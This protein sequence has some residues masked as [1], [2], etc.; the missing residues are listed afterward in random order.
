VGYSQGLLN[1]Q[2]D[3]FLCHQCT[4]PQALLKLSKQVGFGVSF[5]DHFFTDCRP[6]RFQFFNQKISVILTALTKCAEV[7]YQ[8]K[9][10]QVVLVAAPVKHKIWG[11]VI[12]SSGERLSGVF[13]KIGDA[14]ACTN[15]FGYYNLEASKGKYVIYTRYFGYE[16][17][18]AKPLQ[19]FGDQE[20]EIVL[21]QQKSLPA[22]TISDTLGS[23]M[24]RNARQS[25]GHYLLFKSRFETM[26]SP[27]G[28][29]D[30]MRLVAEQPGI[31]TGVDGLGGIHVRGGN[32]DQNLILLDDVPVYNPGHMLGI[33]S[34]FNPATLSNTK[35]WK[36][37]FP[38]RYG[39]RVS[40]VLDVR[41]RD[42]NDQEFH[43]QVGAGLFAANALVEGPIVRGR[44][45]FLLAGRITYFDPIISLLHQRP[46]V[47]SGDSSD[48]RPEYQ[49][50]DLNLKANYQLN[51]ANRVY[52][53]VYL[54]GDQFYNPYEITNEV[55]TGGRY[56]DRYDLGSDWGN[57][58]VAARWNYIF[59]QKNMFVNTTL[60]YSEFEYNSDL[61]FKSVFETPD[62]VARDV[63]NYAQAYRTLIS[64]V[65]VKSDFT[66]NT[67][68]KWQ[69]RWGGAVTR[70]VLR[71]GALSVNFKLPKQGQVSIDSLE[72]LLANRE[73]RVN[74]EIEAYLETTY[75]PTPHWQVLAGINTSLFSTDNVVY[76]L[77]L[78]RVQVVHTHGRGWSQW[79]ALTKNGQ[80]LHQIGSFNLSLP[81]ELWVPTTS[82]IKPETARQ[83][84]VGFGKADDT[85]SFQTELYYKKQLNT[86]LLR[87]AN[88]ALLAGGAEDGSGWEDRVSTGQ[89]ASRGLEV[90]AHKTSGNTRG[91]VAYTLS[92][93]T[94]QFED[95]NL[96]RP[97]LF[98][99]DRTHDFK[100]NLRQRINRW[101][102]TEVAWAYATG[103]PIT[104]SGVKYTHQSPDV[105]FST[106][107]DVVYFSAVNSYRLPAY[108]R[109]DATFNFHF[110]EKTRIR[111]NLQVGA[112]NVYN[113]ANPFYIL[114]DASGGIPGKAKQYTLFPTLPVLRYEIRI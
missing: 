59:P 19:V 38:A 92:R 11:M 102:D 66:Y 4:P 78:P 58:V 86:L 84:N 89:G 15:E 107:R 108:H 13:V 22:V 88:D 37:D 76:P 28:E 111:H 20:V 80:N 72:S 64:D 57:K 46:N 100:I 49:Y 93:T 68:E 12:D 82:K 2:V 101:L 104:L 36:G 71:P 99:F 79:L 110:G 10:N 25:D 30:L 77:V 60:R 112:Y 7:R 70:H 51:K 9:D 6:T 56:I 44:G 5:S 48:T 21:K 91:S 29:H 32:A 43:A 1:Q 113:R 63:A 65:S 17:T 62:R 69:W 40:S 75:S 97:F 94:R 26:G 114:V 33:F 50:Y 81:F 103:N 24:G 106:P 14:S 34:I 8:C 41:L 74:Y 16:S 53:S 52:F 85:W 98:R 42:G 18:V 95:V 83:V 55:N 67:S 39:G 23:R 31:Q 96:G 109:L 87:S 35:L 3:T 54:G 47:L 73:R 105:A 45:S 90:S 27:G 61:G